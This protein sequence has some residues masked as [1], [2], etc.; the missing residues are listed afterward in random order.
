MKKILV[1]VDRLNS[2]GIS[3]V[4]LNIAKALEKSEYQFDYICYENPNESIKNFLKKNK[5]KVFVINR[6]RDNNPLKYIKQIRKI[7]KENGPYKAIHVHTSLFIWL[8][9]YAAK[10]EKIHIRIGHAHGSKIQT[11]SISIKI[12]NSFLKYLNRRYCTKMLTCAELS[13][14]TNF[15]ADYK[16]LPNFLIE[17]EYL[18]KIDKNKNYY[19]DFSISRTSKILAYIG[20]IGGEKNTRF[21]VDVLEKL[22]QLDKEVILLIIGEGRESQEI[23]NLFY[24]KKLLKN[25]RMLGQRND[26]KELLNFSDGLVMPSLSEGMSLAIL[27]AQILG[28]P[29]IVS[30]GVPNTNDIGANLFHKINS[31]DAEDWANNIN[32]ILKDNIIIKRDQILKCLKNKKYD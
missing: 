9:C 11:K 28:K 21:L 3:T 1:V 12:F 23:K 16:F 22:V 5:S 29:C 18:K 30:N 26:V 27:E 25:V 7:I 32:K 15:G 20:Y 10:K 6:L 31:F 8:A 17:E 4:V 24:E 19:D 13:G 2:G 14:K